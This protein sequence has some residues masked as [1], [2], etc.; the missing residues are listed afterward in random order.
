MKKQQAIRSFEYKNDL[1]YIVIR[2]AP[3]LGPKAYVY[4]CGINMPRF[5]PIFWVKAGIC[6]NPAFKGLQQL[7]ADVSTHGLELGVTTKNAEHIPCGPITPTGGIG[8]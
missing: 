1:F 6:S 7:R 8:W 4:C 2:Q 3:E 5:C